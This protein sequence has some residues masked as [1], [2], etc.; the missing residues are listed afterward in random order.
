MNASCLILLL[1]ACSVTQAREG[2]GCFLHTAEKGVWISADWQEQLEDANGHFRVLYNSVGDSSTREDTALDALFY[3][4]HARE[5]YGELG[6]LLPGPEHEP[7]EVMLAPFGGMGAT[8][9]GDPVGE[10]FR[11]SILLDNDFTNWGSNTDELLQVTTAHEYFH[12]LQFLHGYSVDDLAYYEATAVWA[13]DQVHPEVND[14]VTRYAPLFLEN[15]FLPL[16]TW[17][18][19]RPYGLVILIKMLLAREDGPEA[20]Q[21]LEG[22][23]P[24]WITLLDRFNDPGIVLCDLYRALGF[25]GTEHLDVLPGSDEWDWP[26]FPEWDLL[27]PI[28][29]YSDFRSIDGMDGLSVVG[30]RSGGS[31]Y[32]LEWQQG[33]VQHYFVSYGESEGGVHSPELIVRNN[34]DLGDCRPYSRFGTVLISNPGAASLDVQFTAAPCETRD[35]LVVRRS[36]DGHWV[37]ITCDAVLAGGDG[38]ACLYDIRGARIACE[39]FRGNTLRFRLDG[40]AYGMY[41]L[42]SPACGMSTTFTYP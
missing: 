15:A 17:G 11:S 42:D 27:S 30:M 41:I 14:W 2:D 13:E 40:L 1:L 38:S 7:V 28:T 22:D 3:L 4:L 18:G 25:L 31:A 20:L 36:A 8:I 23:S 33:V 16:D 35:E 34:P 9:P 37:E 10:G 24:R 29:G 39:P 32:Q 19:L 21:L 6:F 5:R 12:V 26:R